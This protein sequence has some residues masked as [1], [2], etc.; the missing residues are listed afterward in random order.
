MSWTTTIPGWERRAAMRASD[1]KRRSKLSFSASVI[2]NRRR[3]ALR[4]TRRLRGGS[5][6]VRSRWAS[7]SGRTSGTTAFMEAILLSASAR[8]GPRWRPGPR[9]PAEPAQRGERVAKVGGPRALHPHGLAR[10]R[11]DETQGARVQH[12]P[13]HA[14]GRAMRRGRSVDSV[15]EDGQPHVGQVNADLVLPAGGDLDLQEGR[16][17]QA[18]DHAP[19]GEGRAAGLAGP[20]HPPP[21]GD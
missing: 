2:A 8:S 1:R 9:S 7:I 15:A 4:A 10:D 20:G 6:P 5:M 19:A 13:L 11:M 17:R 18:L 14:D 3:T 21:S 12:L 16:S